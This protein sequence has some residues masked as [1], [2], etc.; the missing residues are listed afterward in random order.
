[1]KTDIFIDGLEMEYTI[2]SD[3]D[4]FIHNDQNCVS[5]SEFNEFCKFYYNFEKLMWS[6]WTNQWISNEHHKTPNIG[7]VLVSKV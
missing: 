3:G 7:L 4:L 6:D 1:M 5:V 2:K